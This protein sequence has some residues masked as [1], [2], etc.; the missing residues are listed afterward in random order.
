MLSPTVAFVILVLPAGLALLYDASAIAFNA[1]WFEYNNTTTSMILSS[2]NW[3]HPLRWMLF[4]V[5]LGMALGVREISTTATTTGNVGIWI[6]AVA[7]LTI[8]VWFIRETRHTIVE[9][10][11]PPVALVNLNS[12]ET[13]ALMTK[14]DDATKKVVLVT[15]ANTGIGLETARQLAQLPHVTVVLCCRSLTK[16]KIARQDILRSVP[17]ATVV[18]QSLDLSSLDSVKN[19]A[20]ELLEEFPKIDVLVHNA[21]LMH[22]DCLQTTD[23]L[24]LVLQVNCLAPFLLTHLLLPALKEARIINVVSSTYVLA[25]NEMDEL[26]TNK[27]YTMFGQY[28]RSKLACILLTAEWQKRGYN[29]VALHP[30]LVRTDVVRYMPWYLR[31]PNQV[32]ASIVAMLQKTPAQG[33]WCTFHVATCDDKDLYWVNRKPQPIH[34]TVRAR[35]TEASSSAWKQAAELVGL[36]HI[37]QSTVG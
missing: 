8:S 14:N 10:G 6:G 16:A 27:Q 18:C 17:F 25:V 37:A 28:A 9:G 20:K 30:G 3:R 21:G 12:G 4:A 34:E 1:M 32:F 2:C 15:G 33:A 13:S 36:E 35:L 24:E 5:S 31:Y 7:F 23:K 26:F 11:S 29:A 19:A 22:K